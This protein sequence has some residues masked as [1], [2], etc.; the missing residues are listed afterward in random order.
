M[1]ERMKDIMAM[2]EAQLTASGKDLDSIAGADGAELLEVMSH[3]KAAEQTLEILA[4]E[5][6]SVQVGDNAPDFELQ[7]LT[8]YGK[9]AP[10]KLSSHFGKRPVALIFGSYT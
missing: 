6:A 4:R 3:P 1:D 10:V 5:E 8:S 7:G 9:G 2:V